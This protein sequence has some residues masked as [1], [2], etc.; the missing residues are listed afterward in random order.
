M[1]GAEGVAI[2]GRNQPVPLGEM[3]DHRAARRCGIL[4][5]DIG[6]VVAGRG[7]DIEPAR[8]QPGR[9]AADAKA[10][11]ADPAMRAQSGDGG[12]D[13]EHDVV[14]VDAGA[15]FARTPPRRL[16]V[17]EGG[18]ALL[19]VV[20][21][22]RRGDVAARRIGIADGAD[23]LVHAK[24]LLHDDE[25]APR[26]AVGISAI[27]IERVPIA[28]LE[29][30]DFAHSTSIRRAQPRLTPIAESESSPPSIVTALP[31]I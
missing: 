30:N 17:V 7:I 26:L 28:G 20:D 24:R 23:M 6:R 12:R 2:G 3:H 29:L 8:R 27:G 9:R 21:R 13:V 18:A 25:A 5:A 19:T 22:R 31:L 15:E 16:V 11:D 10:H 1:R 4:L 14:V